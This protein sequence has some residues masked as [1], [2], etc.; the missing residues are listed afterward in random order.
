MVSPPRRPADLIGC[1]HY[2]IL[3]N[4]RGFA[5]RLPTQNFVIDFPGTI[6]FSEVLRATNKSPMLTKNNSSARCL[7]AS[8]LMSAVISGAANAAIVLSVGVDD[9]T[10]LVVTIT[11][12]IVIPV[13]LPEGTLST[14]TD[15]RWGIRLEDVFTTA[16]AKLLVLG[17]ATATMTV[18]A[19]VSFNLVPR[20]SGVYFFGDTTGNDLILSWMFL[21]HSALTPGQSGT[22]STGE[23]VLK[24]FLSDG[25]MPDTGASSVTV[26]FIESGRGQGYGS[27]TVAYTSP[28]PE[29]SGV[30][31]AALGAVGVA[32][33]RRR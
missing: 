27:T 30:V 18:P 12:E 9:P 3:E 1:A 32:L 15:N 6:R 28:V 21:Q 14:P 23:Y 2:Y 11:E 26:S 4:V 29:P 31:L 13:S 8:A 19:G 16:Q 20:D 22:V 33:R 25:V 7:L 24:G 5:R 17:E 10:D